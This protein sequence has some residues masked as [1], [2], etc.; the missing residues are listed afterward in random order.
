MKINLYLSLIPESLIASMLP[1]EEFGAYYATGTQRNSRGRAIFFELPDDFSAPELFSGN[2]ADLC[3]P[4]EDGR[5][6]KSTYLSVY[7]VLERIPRDALKRL[8]LV[9]ADGKV[10]GLDCG[11]QPPPEREGLHLYQELCPLRPR[12]VSNLGPAAFGRRLTDR[13]QPVSV[14]RI[15]F[16]ELRLNGLALDPENGKADD[17]PYANIAHLRDCLTTVRDYPEKGIKAVVRSM[18]DDF[19]YR[20]L[21]GGF[22]VAD[23]SGLSYFP[24]PTMDQLEREHYDWW[25]SALSS[26]A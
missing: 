13:S 11:V 2:L 20:T 1:P 25:R 17:L 7:R 4:H 23:A 3:K 5:P 16:C 24:L 14:D 22:Y 6:R 26:L 18:P 19:L 9:T 21:E 10:L 8:Y 12:V 15:A